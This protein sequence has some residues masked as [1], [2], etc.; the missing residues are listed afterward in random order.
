[1]LSDSIRPMETSGS[2]FKNTNYH[3][4]TPKRW[5]DGTIP[6]SPTFQLGASSSRCKVLPI[7][8]KRPKLVVHGR[9]ETYLFSTEALNYS[10]IEIAHLLLDAGALSMGSILSA[11]HGH[12][13]I[14][15]QHIHKGRRWKP[16][17]KAP[18]ISR[19]ALFQNS[20]GWI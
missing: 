20:L 1:M 8:A 2:E 6:G 19:P 5:W 13:P 3:G 9:T 7:L 18:N 17:K 4:R 16:S 12:N 15:N 14:A 10:T 11:F